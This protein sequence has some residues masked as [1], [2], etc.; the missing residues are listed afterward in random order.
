MRAVSTSSPADVIHNFVTSSTP[1]QERYDGPSSGGAPG[2]QIDP[3]HPNLSERMPCINRG[4][5]W[6]LF[7]RSTLD[8]HAVVHDARHTACRTS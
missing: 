6:F 4:V 2:T 5:L 1:S 8:W 7:E 3:T